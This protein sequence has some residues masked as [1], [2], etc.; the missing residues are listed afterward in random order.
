MPP[1]TTKQNKTKQNKTNKQTKKP[2]K[3]NK[4][5]KKITKKQVPCRIPDSTFSQ[6]FWQNKSLKSTFLPDPL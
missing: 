5:T 6:H 3:P 4:T 1:K 2:N